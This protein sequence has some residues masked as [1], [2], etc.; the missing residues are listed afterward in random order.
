[1]NDLDQSHIGKIPEI[2]K[3]GK[4]CILLIGG[5]GFLDGVGVHTP[6]VGQNW[7][8]ARSRNFT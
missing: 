6:G 3:I 5:H 7:G 1:M 2:T 4:I 8:R